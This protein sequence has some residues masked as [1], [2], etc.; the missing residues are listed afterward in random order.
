M[1]TITNTHT[2]PNGLRIIHRECHSEVVYCGYA[3]AAGTRHEGGNERGL[4][5]LCEHMSFKG[6]S[7]RNSTNIINCLE[8]V[9]GDL[10]AFTNKTATVYHAAL[11]RDY[12][13]KA[14][15][16]LTDIVFDS[17]YPETELR[18]EIEVVCDEIES[19]NDS[20]SE[21]IFDDLEGMLFRGH[22]LSGSILGEADT[23]RSYTGADLAA[24]TARHYHPANAVFF[25]YGRA[26]FRKIVEWVERAF[27]KI[28]RQYGKWEPAPTTPL[29]AYEA[30]R[31]T[32]S[33]DTHQAHV[34][35]GN[36]AYGTAHP[37]RIPAR[38]LNNILG[39]PGM[40]ARLNVA[41]REKRGLV[42]SVDSTLANYTDTGAWCAYL[43]C[44]KADVG[45]C[46]RILQGQLKRMA[47]KPLSEKALEAAKRQ[48]VG[49]ISVASDNHEQMALDLGLHYL[50]T[51]ETLDVGEVCGKI[52]EVKAEEVQQAAKELFAPG[53]LTTV[54][55]K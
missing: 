13:A 26:D 54:V 41:L 11:L 32:I 36:R 48:M 25:A 29:P 40:N 21:L 51:G 37:L 24:F 42:Y 23:L 15:G 30:G 38:L 9:G 7:R 55:Y 46:L 53:R 2:L 43:G 35:V 27:A 18:K 47:D 49:Q 44:D 33:K 10:N 4:A 22:P 34:A 1:E 45:R 12:A 17:T 28:G 19:Y 8:K 50:H 6:T 52:M 31:A 39:G 3:I 14:V 20:P 5:H 16:L